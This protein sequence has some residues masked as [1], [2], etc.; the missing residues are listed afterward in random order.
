MKENQP[1]SNQSQSSI[2]IIQVQL[3]NTNRHLRL[4]LWFLQNVHYTRVY[5]IHPLKIS[6]KSLVHMQIV[7]DM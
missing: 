4:Q 2:N 1:D 5:K 7:V 3:V 6:F